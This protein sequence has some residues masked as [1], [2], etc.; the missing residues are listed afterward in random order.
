MTPKGRFWNTRRAWGIQDR[1]GERVPT[2]NEV[3]RVSKK[4]SATRKKNL[5]RLIWAL[6]EDARRPG[7]PL[8]A[9]LRECW[10]SA[11]TQGEYAEKVDKLVNDIGQKH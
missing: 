4:L 8:A 1:H 10:E 5:I 7:Q 3:L 2:L 9:Q 6:S 11:T